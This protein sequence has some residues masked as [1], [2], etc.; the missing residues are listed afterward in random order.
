MKIKDAFLRSKEIYRAHPLNSWVLGIS[1]ALFIAA[2]VAIDFIYP[3]LFYLFIPLLVLPFLF[4]FMML[5][6]SLSIKDEVSAK[7]TFR[8]F[9]IYFTRPFRS[10]FRVIL[11]FFK[12]I[13]VQ[14]VFTLVLFGILYFSY[15]GYYGDVFNENFTGLINT[16]TNQTTM[17]TS[18]YNTAIEGYLSANGNMLQNFTYALIIPSDFVAVIVFCFLISIESFSIYAR[19]SL[20]QS[21]Q[22]FVRTSVKRA[23]KK[24]KNNFYGSYLALNWPLFVL[25]VVGMIG[26]SLAMLFLFNNVNYASIV[27]VIC[28]FILTSFFLP[29]YFN[30]MQSLYSLLEPDVKASSQELAREMLSS[31]RMQRELN[32]QEAKELQD[33]ID[34]LNKEIDDQKDKGE[35]LEEGKEKEKDP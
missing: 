17:S 27:G 20:P 23:I 12:M 9:G 4:A 15:S 11:S 7:N 6:Y 34:A 32:E 18:A 5:N 33:A 24:Q 3:G 28:G 13:I 30:N 2:V 21:T 35:P 22:V 25:L 29:F 1:L 26:G 10:S 19:L 16:F 8:L 31:I 14:F